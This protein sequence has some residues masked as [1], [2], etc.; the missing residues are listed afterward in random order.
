M[1]QWLL[2]TVEKIDQ[3]HNDKNITSAITI[4]I[5]YDKLRDR[6]QPITTLP[7]PAMLKLLDII[8]KCNED[9]QLKSLR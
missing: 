3:Q 7:V 4:L 5:A 6:Q 2:T 9:S 1:M 8:C